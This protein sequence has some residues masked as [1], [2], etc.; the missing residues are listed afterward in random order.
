MRD[1]PLVL[2]IDDEQ[3]LIERF[4]K[5]LE[6]LKSP[7]VDA[8]YMHAIADLK[9]VEYE[10]FLKACAT[11]KAEGNDFKVMAPEGIYLTLAGNANE[12]RPGEEGPPRVSAEEICRELCPAMELIQLRE[13]RFYGTI[14][15]GK[16]ERP[17]AWS[18]LFRRKK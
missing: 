2:L 6:R 1:K 4:N 8:L 10:P 16:R 14:A 15:D 12:V 7:Y 18:A 5:C 9:M 13:I 11:L 17:L 3:S